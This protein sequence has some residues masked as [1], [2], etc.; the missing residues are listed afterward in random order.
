MRRSPENIKSHGRGFTLV[1]LLIVIGV[2]LV[3]IGIMLPALGRMHDAARK[4]QTMSTLGALQSG[5]QAYYAD[6]N[7]YP[8][9]SGNVQ[10]SVMLAQGL[11]GFMGFDVDGAG[12]K[13]KDG[14]S[15]PSPS[16]PQFGFRVAKAGAGMSAMGI[17]PPVKGPYAS[18]DPKTFK[19]VPG[20]GTGIPNY[21]FVDGWYDSTGGISH[22]I[23]YLRSTRAPGTDPAKLANVDATKQP[24]QVFGTGTITSTANDY[25]FDTADFWAVKDSTGSPISAP[26]GANLKKLNPPGFFFSQIGANTNT[27]TTT[28]SLGVITG[29]SSYLLISAGPDGTYFTIDDLIMSK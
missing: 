3:L 21:Y 5:L 23:L 13:N 2:I 22:E 28:T 12:P 11:M 16:D 10:G 24:G 9:S 27:A 25:Y 19:A 8:P 7:M 4:A 29:A 20:S 1:E 6:F 15:S 17:L 18:P 26:G 14:N